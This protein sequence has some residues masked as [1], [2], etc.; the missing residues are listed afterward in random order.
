MGGLIKGNSMWGSRMI[1]I[2]SGILGDAGEWMVAC[3]G[4]KERVQNMN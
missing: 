4:L 3:Y 2:M 1:A